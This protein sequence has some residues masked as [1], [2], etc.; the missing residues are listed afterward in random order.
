MKAKKVKI[1]LK[2]P[3][4]AAITKSLREAAKYAKKLAE[5]TNTKFI[6]RTLKAKG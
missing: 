3:E 2:S 4:K 5:Q 6:T 1:E